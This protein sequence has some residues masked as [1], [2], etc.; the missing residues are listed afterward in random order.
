MRKVWEVKTPES[1]TAKTTPPMRRAIATADKREH[2]VACLNGATRRAR[3]VTTWRDP[4]RDLRGVGVICG[5]SRRVVRVGDTV[6]VAV[7]CTPRLVRVRVE[8]RVFTA[9]VAEVSRLAVRV[10]A[11]EHTSELQSRFDLVC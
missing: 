4:S 2:S 10:R 5:T 7:F 9:P 3:S 8:L 11:E 1:H 6:R